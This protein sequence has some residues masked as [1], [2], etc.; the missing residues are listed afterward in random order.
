MKKDMALAVL[1]PDSTVREM[2]MVGSVEEM[3]RRLEVLLGEQPRAAEDVSGRQRLEAERVE[4][5]AR[6][7][8]AGGELL[9]AAFGFLG[10]LLGAD[11]APAA[12]AAVVERFRELLGECVERDPGG[13]L[14]MTVRLPDSTALERL[15]GTLATLAGRRAG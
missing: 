5:R 10:E 11:S 2:A 14:R 3:K 6:I 7:E 13:G 15:A 1:D 8:S 9:G 12:E 4:R